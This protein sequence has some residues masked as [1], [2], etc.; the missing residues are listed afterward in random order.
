MLFG[1]L[2]FRSL[3]K[4]RIKLYRQNIYRTE[5]LNL[6][7]KISYYSIKAHLVRILYIYIIL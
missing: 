2:H 1:V 5:M 7:V 4:R 3:F 6:N